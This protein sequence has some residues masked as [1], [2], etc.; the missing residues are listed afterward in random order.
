MCPDRGRTEAQ[1]LV[2]E[3]YPGEFLAGA[4]E[5]EAAR[6]EDDDLGVVVGD[7]TP[8]DLGRG[9]SLSRELISSAREA[10]HLG[11]PVAGGEGRVEPLHS[12]DTGPSCNGLHP[13]G[14]PVN[15]LLKFAYD[16]DGALPS[17]GRFT[18]LLNRL[19]NTAE[20]GRLE[21]EDEAVAVEPMARLLD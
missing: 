5:R 9:P 12:E 19:E 21:G 10:N 7:A 4:F 3:R 15:P 16:R 2:R 14:D 18:N 6:H 11:Y 17:P 13:R 20:T 1:P 8:G